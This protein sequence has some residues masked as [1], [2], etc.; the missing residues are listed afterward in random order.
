[1]KLAH[2]AVVYGLA[3]VMS[4]PV[5]AQQKGALPP[6]GATSGNVPQMSDQAWEYV[7]VS[8]GKTL[9]G[10]PQKTL[11]YRALGL[12]DGKEGSELQRSL[13]ILGRFGWEV[14]SVVGA[15]GG[16]QQLI[17]KRRFDR[18]RSNGESAAIL[19]G[20]ELYIKDLI[21]ILE[22]EQ[23]VRDEAEKAAEAERG[24]PRLVDLDAVDAQTSRKRRIAEMQ[25]DYM[26]VLQRSE[27][28]KFATLTAVTLAPYSDNLVVNITVDLTFM[29]DGNTYRRSVVS[30]YLKDQ[31]SQFKFGQPLDRYASIQLRGTGFV[32][33]QGQRVD[34]ATY[35]AEVDGITGRWSGD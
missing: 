19:R 17:L 13:D 6:A 27:I 12:P 4:G 18:A 8:Y 3:I 7:V 33:F 26:A 32:N 24:K 22:R 5:L 15:I 31:L 25:A 1:M 21:D 2:L 23:R 9:F 20:R 11:A 29:S 35:K 16:D 10:A 14:V 34:V 28:A 30:K